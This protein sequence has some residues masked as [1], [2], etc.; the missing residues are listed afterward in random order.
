MRMALTLSIFGLGITAA[1][2][3]IGAAAQTPD[4]RPVTLVVPIAAGG[5][6]DTIGRHI[7][8]ETR[9]AAQSG[10]GGGEPHRRRRRYRP[11]TVAKAAPD[12]HT[13]LL[14]ETSSVLHKWLHKQRAVRRRR[15]FRAGGGDR[16]DADPVVC[17]TR[18]AGGGSQ[19][20]DRLRQGQSGQALGRHARRRHAAPSRRRDAQCH[21][22]HRHHPRA[23][24]GHGAGAERSAR[25]PDSADLVDA[26]C[27]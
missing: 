1:V 2:T 4:T 21:G 8:G 7:R 24:Q 22:R 20:T 10:V 6:V 3:A 17:R 9:R 19:G 16:D 27:R 14:M 23:V 13:M 12:G 25:R 15:R 5:G 11:D 18:R 26:E